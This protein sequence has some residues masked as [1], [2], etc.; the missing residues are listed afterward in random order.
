MN[1]IQFI[2][3]RRDVDHMPARSITKPMARNLATRSGNHSRSICCRLDRPRSRQYCP[4]FCLPSDDNRHCRDGHVD[5]WRELVRGNP[6]EGRALAAL[7]DGHASLAQRFEQRGV[8]VVATEALAVGRVRKHVPGGPAMGDD[9]DLEV[10]R[11]DAGACVHVDEARGRFQS[12]IE[13]MRILAAACRVEQ[14]PI[15]RSGHQVECI[16]IHLDNRAKALYDRPGRKRLSPCGRADQYRY[17][18][19]CR[20]LQRRPAHSDAPVT[21]SRNS[22][23]LRM[24]GMTMV[25]PTTSPML[26]DSMISS[27]EAP[28]S[29]ALPMW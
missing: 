28:T 11:I 12:L 6:V 18:C 3:S 29:T 5:L 1:E 23:A 16:F 2:S 14:Q 15:L 7:T 9:F 17:Q 13:G 26:M 22:T 24:C 4:T 10:V 27:R 19:Q 25:P 8:R 21:S 20:Q